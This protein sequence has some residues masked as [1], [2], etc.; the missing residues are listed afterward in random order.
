MQCVKMT[1][2]GRAV[3]ACGQWEVSVCCQ[4]SSF[5]AWSSGGRGWRWAGV[6]LWL[7]C[8]DCHCHGMAV[9][10]CAGWSEVGHSILCVQGAVL[11]THR[12]SEGLRAV[13]DCT[14]LCGIP[15]PLLCALRSRVPTRSCLLTCMHIS[16]WLYSFT[17]TLSICFSVFPVATVISLSVSLCCLGCF[18]AF[19]LTMSLFISFDNNNIRTY[20]Q[21]LKVPALCRYIRIDPSKLVCWREQTPTVSL[22]PGL[23][24][25]KGSV[26]TCDLCKALHVSCVHPGMLEGKMC[27]LFARVQHQSPE[28]LGL[29]DGWVNSSPFI[30]CIEPSCLFPELPVC[31]IL[32]VTLDW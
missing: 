20:M 25:A 21:G 4:F 14:C 5:P 15:C 2:L 19:H 11:Q 16:P 12:G 24:E 30:T 8:E 9:R 23:A 6:Q 29:I 26:V 28:L 27:L 31:P 18:V 7:G 32:S 3:F 17:C 10:V 1:K 22:L 13:Q